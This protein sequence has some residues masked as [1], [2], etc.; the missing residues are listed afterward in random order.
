MNFFDI[1]NNEI[2]YWEDNILNNIPL[3]SFNWL[4]LTEC[5]G[6]ALIEWDNSLDIA[7][8]D[9]N[10][11][12]SPRS[13]WWWVISHTVWERKLR[14][15]LRVEKETQKLYEKELD[16]IK[17]KL[18]TTQWELVYYM[19][20]EHRKANANLTQFVERQDSKKVLNRWIFDIWF[21]LLEDRKSYTTTSIWYSGISWTIQTA[22]TNE[23]SKE[24]YPTIYFIFNSAWWNTSI[25]ITIDWF[26]YTIPQV[27]NDWD[28]IVLYWEHPSEL[29]EQFAYY[30]TVTRIKTQWRYPVLPKGS[31]NI[32]NI[33]FDW[34]P[35]VDITF[36]YRKTYY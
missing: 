30:N 27:V 22:I 19:A 20:W 31:S 8:I 28:V 36:V 23:W 6:I 1:N 9:L 5:S 32:I 26:T 24:T 35:N 7:N 25:W 11:Y 12:L 15:V 3:V 10:S 4:N 33:T 14:L 13:D 21:T 2:N 29:K 34:T 18:T 17:E 16:F